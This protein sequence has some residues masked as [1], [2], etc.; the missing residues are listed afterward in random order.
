MN[1]S[2]NSFAK[3]CMVI[4]MPS[5][6]SAQ[7][8][9]ANAGIE[10]K[11]AAETIL[12]SM[13]TANRGMIDLGN[14]EVFR[15]SAFAGMDQNDDKKVPYAEF[16]AWDPGFVTVAEQEGRKDAYTT[17]SKIIFSFWDRD[18]NGELTDQEMQRAMALDFQHADL[19]DDAMLT[20]EEFMNGFPI[21]V[22]MRA[23]IRPDL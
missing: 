21:I 5:F 20:K 9:D 22:A 16:S 13:D 1:L 8:T 19:N 15:A 14:L 17:A 11:V 18:A 10:G 2:L 6:V 4:M 7:T 3:V 23:A 12:A